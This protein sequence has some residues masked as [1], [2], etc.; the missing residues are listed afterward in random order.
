MSLDGITNEL[1]DALKVVLVEKITE[2]IPN[3]LK[4]VTPDII[5]HTKSV[6]ESYVIENSDLLRDS[7]AKTDE[8]IKEFNKTNERFIDSSLLEREK[9][10]YKLARCE[11][12]IR[13]YNECM[14]SE[15]PYVPRK[16]RSDNYHVKSEAELNIVD[17]FDLERFKGECEILKVRRDEYAG[18]LIAIDTNIDKLF[19]S[20]KLSRENQSKG[21]KRWEKLVNEDT[22]RIDTKL[23]GKTESTKKAFEKDKAQLRT[24][25]QNRIQQNASSNTDLHTTS[26]SATIVSATIVSADSSNHVDTA[27]PSSTTDNVTV[28]PRLKTANQQSISKSSNSYQAPSS[29]VHTHDSVPI[30]TASLPPAPATSVQ[31]HNFFPAST[32]GNKPSVPHTAHVSAV[33]S[34]KTPVISVLA[35]TSAP[36][37]KQNRQEEIFVDAPLYDPEDVDLSDVID[38]TGSKNLPGPDC[39]DHPPIPPTMPNT[40]VILEEI[41]LRPKYQRSLTSRK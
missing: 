6:I 4:E 17:K 23:G 13:L 3:I 26:Q 11:N 7:L 41:K 28:R 35:P 10:Y 9:E 5:H 15:P 1:M 14:E 24:H 40:Q 22:A 31:R 38:N 39:Q 8:D 19:R 36:T 29:L 25:R 30:T 33:S 37:N 18:K 12:L 20:S 21:L 34:L 16:W 27:M 2:L 32:P